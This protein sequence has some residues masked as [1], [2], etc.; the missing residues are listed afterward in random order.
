MGSGGVWG[1]LGGGFGGSFSR[2]VRFGGGGVHGR[3]SGVYFVNV[4]IFF[5]W[6]WRVVMAFFFC[7]FFS[8]S[9]NELLFRDISRIR[10]PITEYAVEAYVEPRPEKG[11]EVWGLADVR[12]PPMLASDSL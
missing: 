4:C 6:R 10:V 7:S 8:P 11:G 2:G 3:V 9:L 12:A 5:P 1:G